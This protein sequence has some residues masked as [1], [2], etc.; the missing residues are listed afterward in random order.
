M[1][2]GSD[3]PA[4]VRLLQPCGEVGQSLGQMNDQ[5]DEIARKAKVAAAPAIAGAFNQ[6]KSRSDFATGITGSDAAGFLYGA[7][8]EAFEGPAAKLLRMAA[9]RLRKNS[10]ASAS[11]P[12]EGPMPEWGGQTPDTK[13]PETAAVG[14]FLQTRIPGF[15]LGTSSD[16]LARI[17]GL[18]Q[19]SGQ[20]DRVIT[21]LQEQVRQLSYIAKNTA[22]TNLKL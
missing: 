10:V 5:L 9:E 7:L 17:G 19:F 18:N 16:P 2:R 4:A 1:G 11:I 6:F 15:N 8:G 20:Q 13:K 22:E 12:F 14:A 3:D 21:Q